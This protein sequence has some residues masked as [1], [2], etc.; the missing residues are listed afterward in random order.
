MTTLCQTVRGALR[1]GCDS[2]CSQLFTAQ[3]LLRLKAKKVKFK[4]NQGPH[5]PVPPPPPPFVKNWGLAWGSPDT[6][7]TEGF[8]AV[9]LL[10]PNNSCETI[11]R[12]SNSPQGGSIL[13]DVNVKN[14]PWYTSG[15][16]ELEWRWLLSRICVS[17]TLQVTNE[18]EKV[19]CVGPSLP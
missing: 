15:Q 10:P 19:L 11:V 13:D 6:S 16:Q 2:C 12:V 9:V 5:C 4:K 7:F 18:A 8:H 1:N 3:S 14:L 17:F